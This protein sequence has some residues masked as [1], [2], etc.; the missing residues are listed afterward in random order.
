MAGASRYD[1][2]EQAGFKQPDNFDELPTM[3]KAP[4]VF[5]LSKK[6]GQ[7]RGPESQEIR[8]SRASLGA[9]RPFKR[10]FCAGDL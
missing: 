7:G 3:L 4:Q 5:R 10:P 1:L 9:P 8:A 6:L 2:M